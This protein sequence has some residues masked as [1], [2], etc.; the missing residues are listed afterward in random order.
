[1]AGLASGAGAA[2]PEPNCLARAVNTQTPGL[3]VDQP[4]RREELRPEPGPESVPAEVATAFLASE[5]S[6][7]LSDH[8]HDVNKNTKD[9]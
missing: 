7:L 8:L 6:V 3:R 9:A 2:R 1:M 4:A 5:K